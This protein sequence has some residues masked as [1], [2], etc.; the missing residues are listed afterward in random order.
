[1][2]RLAVS[3]LCALVAGGLFAAPAPFP[4]PVRAWVTGWDKPV[5]PLGDCRFDRTSDKLTITVPGKG[6][7]LD[8]VQGR[9]AAP[10]LLRQV[11][12]D[13]VAEVRVGAV[14]IPQGRKGTQKAGLLLPL[15]RGFIT[16][17]R[18]A[19]QNDDEGTSFFLI[20]VRY[21]TIPDHSLVRY[22]ACWPPEGGPAYLRLERR[23]D[24]L[25]LKVSEDG[26]VWKRANGPFRF[27]G[28]QVPQRLRVG[29]VAET[30][31]EATFKAVFDQFKLPPLDSKTR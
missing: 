6:H 2:H 13:F 26:K 22:R 28:F 31:G 10:R 12:G 29:V 18:V 25:T 24:W 27:Q 3:L 16:L 30:T 11:E 1:M 15:G 19:V 9:L 5:D 7:E 23:G 14:V 20:G 8:V 4:Q 21:P 17:Q